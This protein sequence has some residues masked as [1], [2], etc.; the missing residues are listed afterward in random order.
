MTCHELLHLWL[1]CEAYRT[2]LKMV[3]TEIFE[4]KMWVP[5]WVW[6]NPFLN[7]LKTRRDSV[8]LADLM[9]SSSNQLAEILADWNTVLQQSKLAQTK[10]SNTNDGEQSDAPQ[11]GTKRHLRTRKR[12]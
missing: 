5:V 1:V 9:D 7:V 6:G 12:A 10:P 2:A 3:P 8:E 4:D 11:A